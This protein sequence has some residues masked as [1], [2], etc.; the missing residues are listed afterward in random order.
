MNKF[1]NNLIDSLRYLKP[2]A[3]NKDAIKTLLNYERTF[4][5]EVLDQLYLLKI[6]TIDEYIEYFIKAIEINKN[7]I[8]FQEKILREAQEKRED[9]DPMLHYCCASPINLGIFK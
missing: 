5:M 8:K 3:I 4:N 6:L 9:Y 2:E 1:W 7:S